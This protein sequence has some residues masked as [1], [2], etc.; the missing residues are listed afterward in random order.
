MDVFAVG[1]QGSIHGRSWNVV[2]NPGLMAQSSAMIELKK[3]PFALRAQRFMHH[4]I[5]ST[6]GEVEQ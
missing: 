5:T 3:A 6:G 2:P 4:A 1:L